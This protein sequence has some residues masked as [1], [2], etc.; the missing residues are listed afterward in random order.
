MG[1][2]RERVM[3]K[4]AVVCFL[5]TLSSEAQTTKSCKVIHGRA[6]RYCGD[7]QLRI[8]HI[9]THHDFEPDQSSWQRVEGW[10]EAGAKPTG[11]CQDNADLFADF[12]I[13]PTEPYKKGAVQK[14]TVKGAF[15]GV[16]TCGISRFTAV[17]PPAH[18]RQALLRHLS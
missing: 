4:I 18:L 6:R 17:L 13:C 2:G 16:M 10:L 5:L 3:L 12:L 14:A 11:A 15:L 7:G 1:H 8:W 9:G